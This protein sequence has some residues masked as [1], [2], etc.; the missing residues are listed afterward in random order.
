M[1]YLGTRP[2]G[3][4][5]ATR[6]A[7]ERSR[8]RKERPESSTTESAW[9]CL[10]LARVVR[11]E[12]RRASMVLQKEREA[13]RYF[14]GCHCQDEQ[15]HY[16]PIGT[17]PL[18]TPGDEREAARVQHDLHR[19]QGENEVTPRE[20]SD[21]T[22]REQDYCQIQHVFHR[23]RH[24]IAPPL[25]KHAYQRGMHQ[26]IRTLKGT[27]LAPLLGHRDQIGRYRSP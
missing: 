9:L 20:K 10:H 21:Q 3:A 8:W 18:I 7:Q 11:I 5:S 14:S 27:T 22:Q 2:D 12:G 16:L 25:W 24:C 4:K 15:E 19:H 13:H 1:P 17:S 23:Y 6:R 26:P